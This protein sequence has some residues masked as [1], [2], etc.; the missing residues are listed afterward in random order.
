M[1]HFNPDYTI[2]WYYNERRHHGKGPY[3]RCRGNRQKYDFSTRKIK[4]C[5][6]NG[7]KDFAENANKIL[8]FLVFTWS[9]MKSW[10]S[11][12]IAKHHQ[13]FQEH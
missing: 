12:K 13:K 1:T 5:V 2:Q 11:L 7:A 3:G 6:I 10:Q 9:K 4:K 8:L